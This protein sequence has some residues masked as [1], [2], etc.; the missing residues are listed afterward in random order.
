MRVFVLLEKLN[1]LAKH[2]A[3][4]D[5]LELARRA[6]T[7]SSPAVARRI[8]AISQAAYTQRL[9]QGLAKALEGARKD[10][11]AAV[12]FE[13]DLD[14]GWSSHFFLCPDYSPAKSASDEWAADWRSTIKGPSLAA[15][16]AEVKASLG[17]ANRIVWNRSSVSCVHP[18]ETK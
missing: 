15:A 10:Q 2:G 6:C 13:Y 5:L 9:N 17:E 7:E 3:W 8:G 18:C 11:S 12:Y 16:V 4:D 1:R 14:N